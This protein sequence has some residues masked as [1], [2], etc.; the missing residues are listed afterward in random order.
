VF[1]ITEGLENMGAIRTGGQG[2]VYKGRRTGE[3]I[4][5]IK[6]LP[7]PIFTQD[8]TDKHYRDFTNEV[9]KLQRV[10]EQ[11]NPNVVKILGSGISETGGFPFIEMEF[12]DGPDLGDLLKPPHPPVFP[13]KE[14]VKVA[15]QLSGA[16]AHCHRLEVR[17]G[18]IKSNNV[19]YNRHTGN[20]V[21][22]DFGLAILSDEERR[23]SLRQAG[24]IEFMAP[25]QNEGQ[26]LFET[27]VYSFGI[28][29]F[30][31][32]AGQVPF[33][34][35]GNSETA[36]NKVMVAH[37]E[38]TPPD[39]LSLRAALLPTDWTDEQKALEMQ[40]PAWL[41]KLVYKC[42][43]KK[44]EDRF[45]NGE[46]LYHY[47]S[48]HRVYTPEIVDLVKNE[49]GKWQAE[50]TQKNYEL[51]DLRG[52][53]AR[54]DEELQAVH[55]KTSPGTPA[56]TYRATHTV[57]RSAFNALLI[58]LL[59]VGA[60]AVYGLFFNRS[61]VGASNA[62]NTGSLPFDTSNTDRD[63]SGVA[64][65]E[66]S[67]TA[68]T[69][70]KTGEKVKKVEVDD[71]VKQT[72]PKVARETQPEKV[73][74][75]TASETITNDNKTRENAGNDNNENE[76]TSVRYKIRNKAFFHNEPDAAT[77]RNAFIVH[78]NNAVLKPLDEQNG[79]IYVVF[80]NH[81]GQVSKGWLSKEDLV[82]LK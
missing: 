40:V 21:L 23:T 80:T 7:T 25:E 10:N 43:E 71:P 65:S 72:D 29:L 34:L 27:D 41:V 58:V 28:V 44:P 54:Q 8:E 67:N 81:L 74:T 66:S 82:E 3:I 77:R 46:E 76:G 32:L 5:A 24:A 2:S 9:K 42:L 69:R 50:L 60:L 1:T 55:K 33:P 13:I 78:W 48:L 51:Q 15:D 70:K 59:L 68:K 53:I 73:D 20:Y 11:P 79:F 39:L 47:I 22:L 14:V 64:F 38:M 56:S 12:I 45:R 35:G 62:Q 61:V 37:M 17:H 63:Q 75:T 6:L 16:L 31:L 19:K 36:R 57:S 30:E 49:E 26:M 18:D 4:T 52:I